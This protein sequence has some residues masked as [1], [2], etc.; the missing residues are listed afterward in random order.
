MRAEII[1][2]FFHRALRSTA[3]PLHSKF[4]SYAYEHFAWFSLISCI[5][6]INS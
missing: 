3:Q 5:T 2:H 6:S 1:L 4:A